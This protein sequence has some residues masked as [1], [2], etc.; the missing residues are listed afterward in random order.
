MMR[1]HPL[2]CMDKET[3]ALEVIRLLLG[4]DGALDRTPRPEG[5][6]HG[7][8]R[9]LRVRAEVRS[10]IFTHDKPRSEPGECQVDQAVLVDGGLEGVGGA[11]LVQGQGEVVRTKRVHALIKHRVLQGI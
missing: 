9:V 3:S 11:F 8:P 6:S 7:T 4:D 2:Q 1:L 10:P 5:V